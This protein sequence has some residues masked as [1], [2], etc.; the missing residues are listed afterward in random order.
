MGSCFYLKC[1]GMNFCYPACKLPPLWLAMHYH[2][3]QANKLVIALNLKYQTFTSKCHAS[4]PQFTSNMNMKNFFSTGILHLKMV[5]RSNT[6]IFFLP[7]W[8]STRGL[9]EISLWP[10]KK[11]IQALTDLE[12]LF[13]PGK[14]GDL[15]WAN[16][17]SFQR[18]NPF[19]TR[20]LTWVNDD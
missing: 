5:T 16:S 18:R 10:K 8:Q 11:K 6:S 13:F 19:Q 14:P 20:C 17:S 9:K 12:S 2:A 4:N 15:R 1:V 3:I 7:L